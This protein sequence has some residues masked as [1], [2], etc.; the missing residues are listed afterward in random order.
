MDTDN[1]V[2]N[3][4][5]K[6]HFKFRFHSGDGPKHVIMD[7]SHIA[8]LDYTTVQGI[9]ELEADFRRNDVIFALACANVSSIKIGNPTNNRNVLFE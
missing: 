6:L 9:L 7:C 2:Q 8:G 5:S 4:E 1:I 3:L